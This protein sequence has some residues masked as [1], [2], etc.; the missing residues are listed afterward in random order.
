V[1]LL[2]GHASNRVPV[3]FVGDGCRLVSADAGDVWV[4]DLEVCRG[5]K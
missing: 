3:A 1:R 2:P 4:W 5:A